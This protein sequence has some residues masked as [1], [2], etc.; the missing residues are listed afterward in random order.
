[1]SVFK[2][3]EVWWYKFRF[4]N[5]L[6]RESTKTTSKTVARDAEKKRRRELEEGYNN[7]ADNRDDRVQTISTIADAYLEDYKLRHRS[8]VFAE[9]ALGH[10]TR[11]LGKVMQVDISDATVKEYQTA[12]LRE[13]AAPKSVNEEVGFLLRMLGERGDAIRFKMRREKTLKLRAQ[14]GVGKAY[15]PVQKT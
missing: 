8:G 12:R 13:K 10:V 7:L 1:M 4:A 2:R 5:R 6:I 11:V 15:D 3:G 9:Y 14:Q